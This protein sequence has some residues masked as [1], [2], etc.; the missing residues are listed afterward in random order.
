MKIRKALLATAS[1]AFAASIAVPVSAQDARPPR[2]P[3]TGPFT[4]Y[5]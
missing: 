5:K 4:S 3:Q 2:P 1:L